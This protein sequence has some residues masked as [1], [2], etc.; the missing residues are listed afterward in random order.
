MQVDNNLLQCHVVFP[1]RFQERLNCLESLEVAMVVVSNAA[2]E[3]LKFST[4]MPARPTPKARNSSFC[5]D[6]ESEKDDFM[7]KT[8][9]RGSEI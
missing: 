5:S 9:G 2:Q 7:N 3:T 8:Q 1:L 6:F 4:K